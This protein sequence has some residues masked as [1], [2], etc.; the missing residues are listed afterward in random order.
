MKPKLLLHPD[1]W[2]NAVA[3]FLTPIYDQ[4]FDRV[5]IDSETTYNSKECLVYS[6]CMDAEW[7]GTWVDRGF[8]VVVDALWEHYDD[9][10]GSLPKGVTVI[11]SDK[12]FMR[13]N[14]SIWYKSLGLD[15]YQ[16]QPNITK[17]FL[18]FI[19]RILPHR[20]QIW[21]KINLENSLYSYQEKGVKLNHNDIDPND[22]KW[23]RHFD[24]DWYN[25]TNFSMVVESKTYQEDVWHTEKTWKPIA[26]YHPFI[27]WGPPGYISNLRE[28]GFQTF[29]HVIDE[30]YD[31]ELDHVKRLDMIIQQVDSLAHIKLTD[32]ETV[33]RTIHNHNL[34]FDTTWSEKM[35]TQQLFVPLLNLL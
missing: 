34:F 21:E 12:W 5:F 24:P 29:D 23:Q 35:F 18:M 32:H 3:S 31:N 16:R 26:F 2:S 20:D 15:Q 10:K 7:V 33:K 27:L 30:S 25:I 17:T 9:V 6:H 4:Y 28:Q 8:T 14:E 13:A 11:K 19:N 1:K 22:S